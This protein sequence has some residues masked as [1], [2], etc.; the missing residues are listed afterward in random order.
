VKKILLTIEIAFILVILLVLPTHILGSENIFGLKIENINR[1]GADFYWSTSIE[2]K[3]SIE[4]G[5]T[6][7][8]ELYN[9]QTR[10]EELAKARFQLE[11]DLIVQKVNEVDLNTIKTYANELREILGSAS[12]LEQK[13]FLRSFIKRIEVDNDKVMIRYK[14]PKGG[15]SSIREESVLPIVSFG[16]AGGIRTPYLLRVIW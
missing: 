4:Y 10:Q 2:T 6:K 1:N 9:P 5:Y 3:G 7:L 14:L 12:F 8:P 13:T 15:T 11:A 16:G